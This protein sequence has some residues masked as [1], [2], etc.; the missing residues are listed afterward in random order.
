MVYA[1]GGG[2][3][4]GVGGNI[5]QYEEFCNQIEAMRKNVTYEGS[6]INEDTK[7]SHTCVFQ[8]QPH[9]KHN[10]A[11]QIKVSTLVSACA[12]NSL[13]LKVINI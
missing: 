8:S 4:E 5:F 10:S 6:Y 2:P 11:T 12:E 7:S 13:Y 1:V 3:I 9:T